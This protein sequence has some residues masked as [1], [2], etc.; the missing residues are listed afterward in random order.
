MTFSSETA[1]PVFYDLFHT[2]EAGAD[3][4][5][6]ALLEELRPEIDGALRAKEMGA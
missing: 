3:H 5:A 6:T 4:V 2:G 1:E